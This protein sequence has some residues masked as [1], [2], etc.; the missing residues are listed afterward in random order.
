MLSRLYRTLRFR[1]MPRSSMLEMTVISGTPS[2]GLD[3][4]TDFEV[5]VYSTP[6][7]LPFPPPLQKLRFQGEKETLF[8]NVTHIWRTKLCYTPKIDTAAHQQ[9]HSWILCTRKLERGHSYIFN[10]AFVPCFQALQFI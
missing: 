9:S 7:F 4:V 10:E 3:P 8:A 5:I 2:S 1:L 6:F